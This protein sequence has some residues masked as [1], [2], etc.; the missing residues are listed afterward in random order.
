MIVIEVGGLLL[1]IVMGL[2]KGDAGAAITLPTFGDASGIFAATALVFFVYIGFEDVANCR[3]K[4]KIPAA[5]YPGRC[6][7]V[8]RSP[9]LCICRWS[10][11]FSP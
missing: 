5:T 4:R 6:C 1:L 11:P 9:H 10:G 3:K 2:L 7:G 8:W